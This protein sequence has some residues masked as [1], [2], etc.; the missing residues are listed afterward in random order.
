[1]EK[2]NAFLKCRE[3]FCLVKL[4]THTCDVATLLLA[5]YYRKASMCV[6]PETY[7]NVCCSIILIKKKTK[8]TEI[9]ESKNT[10]V[11]HSYYM[12]EGGEPLSF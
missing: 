1:M 9:P 8:I 7:T 4:T 12:R 3:W 11:A 6:Y 2:K 5:P 10:L